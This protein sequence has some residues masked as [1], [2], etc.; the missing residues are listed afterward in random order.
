MTTFQKVV[1][2][3][4]LAFAIFLIVNICFG[5]LS[6]I[7]IVF[8]ISDVYSNAKRIDMVR[9]FDTS[10]IENI[11]ISASISKIYVLKG[12]SIKVEAT[13]VNEN[14]VIKEERGKL[15]IVEKDKSN[16]FKSK[17]TS[18]IRIYLPENIY[19]R[20]FELDS[21]VS[22]TYIEYLRANRVDLDLGVG[23]VTLSK[24]YSNNAKINSGV[25]NLE[26]TDGEIGNA[27]FDLGVGNTN[28]NAILNGNNKIECGVGDVDINLLRSIDGYEIDVDKGLGTVKLNNQ[29]I[30][31]NVKYGEGLN[32]VHIEAG[33]GNI[34]INVND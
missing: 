9:E 34:D 1:K 13:S 11:D 22:D 17:K 5:I 25:G 19:L 16:F 20:N 26:I 33:L 24:I 27:D 12:D 21:G 29:K 30:S 10:S 6:A 8:G 14:T 3:L 4:A 31:E 28:I 15:V 7:G 18:E 2:G 32:K 23:N